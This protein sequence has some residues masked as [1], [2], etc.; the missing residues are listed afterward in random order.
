[1]QEEVKLPEETKPLSDTYHKA[2]RML[3]FLS[4]LLI[5]WEYAGI[6]IGASKI[7]FAE[8]HVTFEN[9]EV[10]PVIILMLVF[11]F[12]FRVAV[13]WNQCNE[14]RKDK[15]AAQVDLYVAY[16][17]AGIALIIYVLHQMSSLRLADILTPFN[18]VSFI[19]GSGV[20][21]GFYLLYFSIWYSWK[22]YRHGESPTS[23]ER[24]IKTLRERSFTCLCACMSSL[25]IS[26][27]L[28]LYPA[29]RTLSLGFG[30]GS[31]I[32]SILL[33]IIALFSSYRH[34]RVHED[35][36]RRKRSYE[37]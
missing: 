11:Y 9:A 3:A 16:M 32:S 12:T 4:G 1:M 8:T 37:R 27:I 20:A 26:A 18:A 10:F 30:A 33:C 7:P 28:Y 36:I 25:A 13:E 2:R 21:F 15:F 6:K 24:F 5:A 23:E 22:K 19:A 34:F 29:L 35:F 17:I 31:V 14:E